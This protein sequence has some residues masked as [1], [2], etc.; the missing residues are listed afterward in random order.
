M[1]VYLVIGFL[2]TAL[3]GALWYSI[4]RNL[5]TSTKLAST[6]EALELQKQEA[7]DTKTRLTE[8]T[9][10]RNRLAKR[11]DQI[12]AV[13]A[14]LESQLESERATRA[15]LERENETYRLWSTTDL[16]DVV[17]SLLRKGS[18]PPENGLPG[19]RERESTGNTGE[20]TGAGVDAEKRRSAGSD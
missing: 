18:I 10:A 19:M 15:R 1:K 4:E 5:E 9:E 13:E 12:R 16:P 6:S 14:R 8:M 3:S 2:V 7:T 11:I 20:S 17:I